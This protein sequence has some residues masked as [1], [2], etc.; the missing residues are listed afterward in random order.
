MRA[1]RQCFQKFSIGAYAFLCLLCI[2]RY[3]E[4]LYYKKT[5]ILSVYQIFTRREQSVAHKIGQVKIHCSYL[6]V[7]LPLLT[8]LLTPRCRVLLEQLTGLHLVKKF[9]AFHGA[10]KFITALTSV[11]HLSLSWAS[12]IQSIPTSHLLEIRPN[13]IH[14]SKPRS[15]HWPLSLRFRHQDPLHPPLLND[16]RHMPSPSHSSRCYCFFAIK[17]LKKRENYVE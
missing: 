5:H 12:P 2:A 17:S 16:T 6:R 3:S 13:F 15:P 10:R 8:Y 14:P 11:R 1:L 9:S 7:S 4:I